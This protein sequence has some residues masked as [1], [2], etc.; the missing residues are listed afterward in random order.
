MSRLPHE[1][2]RFL[3]TSQAAG[4]LACD[5]LQ[6]DTVSSGASGVAHVASSSRR[7]LYPGRPDMAP[8]P[9]RLRLRLGNVLAR[10]AGRATQRG[11]GAPP[12]TERR[13]YRLSEVDAFDVCCGSDVW[14]AKH[15]E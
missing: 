9:T 6:V 15:A 14:K 12:R 4:I 13:G 7:L 1:P 8:D 3:R 10:G 5:F 11:K 2:H